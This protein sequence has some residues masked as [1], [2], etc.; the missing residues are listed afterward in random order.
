MNIVHEPASSGVLGNKCSE[1]SV[2]T[3]QESKEPAKNRLPSMDPDSTIQSDQHESLLSTATAEHNSTDSEHIE[4]HG[5]LPEPEANELRL[6]RRPADNTE[7]NSSTDQAT[8]TARG[9]KGKS[10]ANTASDKEAELKQAAEAN[11]EFSCNICFDTAT[12]PVLTLCGHLFCWSCLVQWLERSATCPVCKAGCDKE[13]V[14]PVYGRGKEE[15]DP[16]QTPTIPNRPQGQRPPP[17]LPRQANQFFGFDP[18]GVPGSFHG[19]GMGRGGGAVFVGGFGFLPA[20]MGLSAFAGA[21]TGNAQ[22]NGQPAGRQAF[23]SRVL[24]MLAV[25]ILMSI[26]FY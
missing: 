10:A 26:L 3:A 23:A 9:D 13:K 24:M 14:I 22:A 25:M 7:S 2:E 6:R 18:F 4:E 1:Y 16:R 20:L 5:N 8:T 19:V 21:Q 11:D 15:K 12:D 17:P